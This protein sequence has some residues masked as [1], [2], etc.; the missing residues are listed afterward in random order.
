MK[1]Y[2]T[3]TLIL[4]S[5]ILMGYGAW[6]FIFWFITNQSNMLEWTLFAKLIYLFLSMGSATQINKYYYD[7]E[8]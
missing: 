5:S 4:I 3:A 8:D 7:K 2:F 1:N 6:Y